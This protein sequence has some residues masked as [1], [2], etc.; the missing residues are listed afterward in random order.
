MNYDKLPNRGKV[1]ST[2]INTKKHNCSGRCYVFYDEGGQYHV[3]CENC[4]VIVHYKTNSQ[5]K[6]I[7]IWNT[8]EVFH[9]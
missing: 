6:A 1:T 9:D 2:G 7:E 4:G 8:M 3:E 5:D